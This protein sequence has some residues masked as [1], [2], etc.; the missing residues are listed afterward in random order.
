VEIEGKGGVI[1]TLIDNVEDVVFVLKKTFD[2]EGGGDKGLGVENGS[3][4][5]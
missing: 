2:E 4:H 1:L 3:V 5:V